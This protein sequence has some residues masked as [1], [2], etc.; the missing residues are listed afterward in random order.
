MAY[1][2]TDDIAMAPVNLPDNRLPL[3]GSPK[4]QC[5]SHGFL[6]E[7]LQSGPSVIL[8]PISSRSRLSSFDKFES[9]P[10]G[11]TACNV[12]HVQP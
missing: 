1:V 12:M 4:V 8:S 9:L 10:F 6:N 11:L 5:S 3:P 7:F 2:N